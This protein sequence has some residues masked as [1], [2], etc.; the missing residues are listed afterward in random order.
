MSELAIDEVSLADCVEQYYLTYAIASVKDRAL[1][2]IEDGQKPVQRRILYTLQGLGLAANSKHVKSARIVGDTIGKLHPHGDQSVYDAAVRMAQPFSLRYVLI[3]GQGNFGSLDGDSPAA[4]RYTEARPTQFADHVLLSEIN[5]GT[6]PFISNYDGEFK[7]PEYLPARLPVGLLNGSIGIAVG[8]TCDIP[9]HNLVEVS[10]ALLCLLKTPSAPLPELMKHIPAPD[11]PYGGQII[12][13][14]ADIAGVYDTGKGSIRMR[15]KWGV[16]EMARGQWKI[17]VTELPYMVSAKSILERI[18]AI[19]NPQ[20]PV[21]KKTITQAQLNL[22]QLALSLISEVRDE[23]DKSNPIRIVIEPKNQKTDKHALMALLFTSTNLEATTTVNMNMVGRDGRPVQKSLRTILT[24]WISFR[25]DTVT[26][27]TQH[28]LS[29]VNARLHI[30]EGRIKV[31][32]HLDEVIQIIRNSDQ[33]KDELISRFGM[34]AIQAE[35]IL[36]IRLRQLSRLEKD[37]ITKEIGALHKEQVDLEKLLADPKL[38]NKLIAKEIQAD[39]SKFGDARRSEIKEEVP[40]E[41]PRQIILDEPVTVLLSKNGWIRTKAG[42]NLDITTIGYKPHDAE[43]ISLEAR[44]KDHLLLFDNNGRV[45]TLNIA[46]LP[47][48]KGDGTPI[49]ALID[50]SGTKIMHGLIAESID[51]VLLSLNTGY[52][53]ISTRAALLSRTKAGKQVLNLKPDEYALPPVLL[54]NSDKWGLF[55]TTEDHALILSLGDLPKLEKGRGVQTIKMAITANLK[56]VIAI[57]QVPFSVPV[58]YRKQDIMLEVST[59][60]FTRLNLGRARKGGYLPK[61]ATIR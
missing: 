49:T 5:Q 50:M 60:E 22:K 8:M 25:F 17:V 47:S 40:A 54:A 36:E 23:S 59:E 32:L 1:P 4:M 2:Q 12:S 41:P 48:G 33:P 16:E 6:V 42:H 19:T 61:K 37:A 39:T 20:P 51:E 44:T 26:K 35:D 11:F 45:Y 57:S 53:F 13:S 24:E 34:S 31:L 15:A 58:T 18:D 46:Q 43:F 3:D 14:S 9:P 28:R 10:N 55:V 38:M 7:E 21:N 29:Q 30:L 56:K 52:S 27:R